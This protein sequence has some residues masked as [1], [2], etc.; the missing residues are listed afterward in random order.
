MKKPIQTITLQKFDEHFEDYYD[1]QQGVFV[2]YAGTR[3]FDGNIYPD[4]KIKDYDGV[5]W[6]CY[7]WSVM[8][9]PSMDTYEMYYKPY[10]D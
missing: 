5:I 6:D 9:I 10:G 1:S 3:G 2:I 4:V 8:Y 7:L